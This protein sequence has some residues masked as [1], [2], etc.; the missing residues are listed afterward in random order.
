MAQGF[1]SVIKDADTERATNSVA[2]TSVRCRLEVN[3]L[4]RF[5][6]S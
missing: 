1:M 4:G 5:V 2:F 6:I 3:D